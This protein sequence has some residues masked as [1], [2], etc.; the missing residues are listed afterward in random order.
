MPQKT[1]GMLYKFFLLNSVINVM[2]GA[3][4]KLRRHQYVA[5]APQ[6]LSAIHTGTVIVII[7][8]NFGFYFLTG[9]QYLLIKVYWYNPSFNFSFYYWKLSQT[10]IRRI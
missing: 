7:I 10:K 8:I 5:Q 3:A 4:S 6:Q 1:T 2:V 9:M